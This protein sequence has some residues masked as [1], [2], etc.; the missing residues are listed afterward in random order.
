MNP[1]IEQIKGGLVVS[2]QAYPGEPLRH[3][4]TM[5]QM[6]MAAEI[7]G[8]VAIRC[9]GLAD[10]AAIKGQVKVP[11]IGIWKEGDEG[12][13]ITPTLRHARCCAAA[14]AD[15]VAIDAT[16]RPRPDGLTYAQTVEALHRDGVTVMADCG[17]FADAQQAVD[18]GTDIISTTLSGYTGERE[19]TDG[20]DFELLEQMI[21]AFPDVP[22]LCEGR[23]HTPDQLAAVMERGAWAAVVGTAITHPTSITRW[24]KARLNG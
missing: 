11:V 24:F 4:E 18:A 3:P 21:A 23:I 22:V 1:I 9:Q 20:P 17:S 7:G 8:A 2:C 19:K 6:A 12:V 14:G 16:R 10:I 5:A 13:Y 15:I